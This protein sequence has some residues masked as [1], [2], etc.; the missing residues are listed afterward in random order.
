MEVDRH[1]VRAVGELVVENV[2]RAHYRRLEPHLAVGGDFVLAYREQIARAFLALVPDRL[3]LARPV[4]AQERPARA[5]PERAR[6]R[7]DVLERHRARELDRE[8][9]H[10]RQVPRGLEASR[11]RHRIPATAGR[12]ALQLEPHA[13]TAHEIVRHQPVVV[14]FER[15]VAQERVGVVLE[16]DLTALDPPGSGQVLVEVGDTLRVGGDEDPARRRA[17]RVEP[18]DERGA[19]GDHVTGDVGGIGAEEDGAE[20]PAL[21]GRG[22]PGPGHLQL[23]A[24]ADRD[25]VGVL[26]GGRREGGQGNEHER[27]RH[28]S[29]GMT[30]TRCRLYP[31]T[32]GGDRF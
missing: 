11:A 24:G 2:G 18:E 4:G 31:E 26:A 16:V 6:L 3:V 23:P 10:D 20:L 21:A 27:S 25:G 13:H 15:D 19:L 8:R 29:S 22:G 32:P 7:G 17:V 5:G 1:L 12:H 30:G 28:I 14:Q 9:F